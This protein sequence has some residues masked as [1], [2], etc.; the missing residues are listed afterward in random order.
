L[1]LTSYIHGLQSDSADGEL[2]RTEK[3]TVLRGVWDHEVAGSNPV[4]PTVIRDEPFD[5][6]VEGLS[7]ISDE[8]CAVEVAVQTD[9]FED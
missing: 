1:F 6:N 5:E 9:D 3:M 2:I 7:H 8:S 4:T